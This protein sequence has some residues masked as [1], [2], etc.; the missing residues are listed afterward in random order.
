MAT[1]IGTAGLQTRKI[2]VVRQLDIH[3]FSG[4]VLS[5]VASKIQNGMVDIT[6]ENNEDVPYVHQRPAIDLQFDASALVTDTAGRAIYYWNTGTNN[7]FVNYDTVYKGDYGTVIGTITAGLMKCNFTELGS[8]LVLLDHEN[9]QGWT[10][11]SAGVLAQISDPDFPTT[12]A[13]GGV[14]LDTYMFVMDTTG[15]IYQSSSSDPTAWNPLDVLN[16]DR[17]PDGGVYL[18]KHHGNIVALGNSTIEFFYDAGNP[19]ASVLQRRN[20]IFYNTG[21]AVADSVW[22]DEDTTMFIGRKT[23]SDM[24]VYILENFQLQKVSTPE[25]DS[26]ITENLTKNSINFTASGVTARGHKYY[27]ITST[28]DSATEK[29][30]QLTLVYDVTTKV[31]YIWS[32]ALTELATLGHFP[33]FDWSVSAAAAD[34]YGTGILSNGDLVTIRDDMDPYDTAGSQYYIV[35]Q[36]DYV[37]TDYVQVYGSGNSANIDMSIRIG[38]VDLGTNGWKFIRRLELEMQP[39]G[40]VGDTI[41]VSWS[42]TDYTTFGTART[43]KL[44]KRYKLTGLGRTNRR[45]WQL[46]YNGAYQVRIKALEMQVHYSSN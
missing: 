30:P 39:T 23:R 11:T 4:A 45:T 44:D 34:H 33:I 28:L 38:N 41:S 26:Y 14:V 22:Y 32:T 2:S 5:D 17:E 24:G 6:K 9:G 1:G 3:G 16:A 37:V 40:I 46:D 31:W 10:I 19:T 43:L 20:D 42:D 36:T 29:T 12:L 21:C 25:I 8:Y 18:T 7:Y 35:N 15:A 27:I 13:G